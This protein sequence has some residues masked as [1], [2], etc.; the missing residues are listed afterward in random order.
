ML[1]EFTCCTGNYAI[2]TESILRFEEHGPAFEPFNGVPLHHV[3]VHAVVVLVPLLVL[4]A[5]AYALIPRLRSRLGWVVVSLA[6][7]AP[8][9]AFFAKESGD[10]FKQRLIKKNLTSDTILAQLNTHE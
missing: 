8:L 5:I 1:P 2:E 4:D 9:T 6:I 7:V 3:L 10:A